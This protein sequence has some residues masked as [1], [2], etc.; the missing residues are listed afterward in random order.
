MWASWCIGNTDIHDKFIEFEV[1]E[2]PEES[3]LTQDFQQFQN[4]QVVLMHTEESMRFL[5][6]CVEYAWRTGSHVA[7]DRPTLRL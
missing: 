2:A 4:V 5:C 7:L 1:E 6:T 3:E